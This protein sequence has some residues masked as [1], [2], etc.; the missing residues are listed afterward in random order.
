MAVG[1]E[2]QFAEF[3]RAL[4]LSELI[5]DERFSTNSAR[6]QHRELLNATLDERIGALNAS[7]ISAALTERKVPFGFV[8]DM[9]AVFE[10]PVSRA[11]C[12]DGGL[13]VRTVA[14]SGDVEGATSLSAPPGLDEHR[15]EILR[16][17]DAL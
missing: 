2:R 11:Q 1:T 9:A 6:V 12:F 7:D 3:S 17:L 16:W 13:G 14:L 10:Q 5:E 15:E 4:G 8:N